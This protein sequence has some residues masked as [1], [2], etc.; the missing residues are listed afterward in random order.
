MRAV[1]IVPAYQAEQSVGEVVCEL[2]ARWPVNG[3]SQTVI[4]V[5]DGSTDQTAERAELAARA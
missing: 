5:D 1:A 3:I 2:S 4:V